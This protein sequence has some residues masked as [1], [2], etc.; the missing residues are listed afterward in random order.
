MV[1]CS[2]YLFGSLENGY[3]QIP[4]DYTREIYQNFFAKSR[5]NSQISIHR[6]GE[7][8]YYGYVRKLDVKGQ[9]I[10]FCVL[11]NGVMF[12]R[13][14]ELFPVFEN[15]FADFVARGV[16]V[17]FDENGDIVAKAKSLTGVSQEVGY[18]VA[19][20]RNGL[21]RLEVSLKKLPPMNYSI[22]KDEIKSFTLDD[23]DGEITEASCTYA[24]TFV[25][26]DEGY[27]TSV[28]L[29]YKSI[30]KKLKKEKDEQSK[31]YFDLE[32]RYVELNRQKKQYKKVVILCLA[33]ILVVLVSGLG[34]FLLKDD[35]NATRKSLVETQSDLQEKNKAVDDM[36]EI[37][38]SL[39]SNITVLE[40]SLENGQK[41]RTEAEKYEGLIRNAQ[42]FFV[43]RTSF[44][45]STGWLDVEYFGVEEK[46]VSL[47]VRIH[48]DGQSFSKTVSR[49]ISKGDNKFS[50]YIDDN[51]N[52]N[53]WY[54]F[55][56]LI[57]NRIIGGDRH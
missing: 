54:S 32:K 22:S 28:M 56:L 35:L 37:N 49:D 23:D 20:I 15:A 16:V 39:N 38:D 14:G 3:S 51:L 11:L 46:V 25:Y 29:G 8:I 19:S 17:G 53:K 40:E 52:S 55:E 6:V 30:I 5:A 7:L 47:D 27:D 9:Y 12:S 26:K 34:L 45:F 33:V 13:T 24:Y 31:R 57:G 2:I 44:S 42:P 43:K 10:G 4:D 21:D 18:V 50:V 41:R 1:N 36:N 48:G